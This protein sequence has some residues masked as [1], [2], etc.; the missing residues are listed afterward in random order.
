MASSLSYTPNDA[1]PAYS[2]SSDNEE[3]GEWASGVVELGSRPWVRRLGARAQVWND[4][5]GTCWIGKSGGVKSGIA[6]SHQ[7]AVI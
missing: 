1:S 3:V 2:L 5:V 6:R 7:L 4:L